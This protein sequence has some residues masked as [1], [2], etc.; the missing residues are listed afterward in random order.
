MHM[1]YM[2]RLLLVFL[3]HLLPLQMTWGAAAAYCSHGQGCESG[4]F[5]HHSHQHLVAGSGAD[6]SAPEDQESG[7]VAEDPDCSLH[8]LG[9]GEPL[10]QAPANV[11]ADPLS[12][13]FFLE[14]VH[15][16]SCP[17]TCIERPKWTL[18]A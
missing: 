10:I 8:H 13:L 2:S 11:V 6:S 15:E 7:S 16:N 1:R 12:D 3:F 18:A 17:P 9:C 4:H 14:D 5:G